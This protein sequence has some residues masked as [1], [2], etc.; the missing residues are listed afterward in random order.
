MKDKG[1]GQMLRSVGRQL[2]VP[3]PS[4]TEPGA[5]IAPGRL[6]TVDWTLGRRCARTGGHRPFAAVGSPDAS[7]SHRP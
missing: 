2:N 3:W 1:Q 6:A 7:G 4:R 5:G